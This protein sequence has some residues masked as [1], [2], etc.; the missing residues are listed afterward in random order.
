MVEWAEFVA[1]ELPSE[2]LA[3]TFNRC[4][5]AGEEVRSVTL[6]PHGGHFEQVVKELVE[7]E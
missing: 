5:Q 2:Y 7:H 6:E 1:D 4:D 3:I